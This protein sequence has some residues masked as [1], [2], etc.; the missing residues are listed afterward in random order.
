M[1]R[2]GIDIDKGEPGYDDPIAETIKV[3]IPVYTFVQRVIRFVQRVLVS[4]IHPWKLKLT[5]EQAEFVQSL[6][7][8]GTAPEGIARAMVARYGRETWRFFQTFDAVKNAFVFKPADFEIEGLEFLMSAMVKLK[9]LVRKVD[10]MYYQTSHPM[11]K[12][13][14]EIATNAPVPEK[15][16]R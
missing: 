14:A 6:F 11:V 7:L 4:I 8:S 1:L 15:K 10:G 16:E 12:K 5:K 2:N 3:D 9:A 13:L